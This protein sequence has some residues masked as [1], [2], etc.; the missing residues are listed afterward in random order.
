MPDEDVPFFAGALCEPLSCVISAQERHIH[1]AQPSPMASRVPKLGL[2]PGGICVVIGAGP[3]G[4]MHAEAALRFSPRHL[5]VMD[6]IP[7]RLKQ[8]L[9]RLS[10]KAVRAGT[11]LHAVEAGKGVA[12]EADLEVEAAGN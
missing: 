12:L 9:G 2:L 1:I 8:I 10:A 11:T 4:Q 6:I 7:E 3:M 5:V